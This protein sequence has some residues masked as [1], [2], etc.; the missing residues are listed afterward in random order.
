MT[1]WLASCVLFRHVRVQRTRNMIYL[2]FAH[3]TVYPLYQV[4]T[5]ARLSH[6]HTNATWQA[7]MHYLLPH[8]H[9]NCITRGV[10]QLLI[11]ENPDW[12][13]DRFPQIFRIRA[14][15]WSIDFPKYIV[16]VRAIDR[17]IDFP[18]YFVYV[19]AIDRLIDWFTRKVPLA[20]HDFAFHMAIFYLWNMSLINSLIIRYRQYNSTTRRSNKSREAVGKSP[21]KNTGK[22]LKRHQYNSHSIPTREWRKQHGKKHLKGLKC[23][24]HSIPTRGVTKKEINK[25]SERLMYAEW[26]MTTK[27]LTCGNKRACSMGVILQK[28]EIW[29]FHRIFEAFLWG[30]W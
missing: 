17:L 26:W 8:L 1:L 15:S 21:Q 3:F 19:R 11:V 30:N 5:P 13:V 28:E 6:N 18:K 4:R 10:M 29:K 27:V 16:Y 25:Q 7:C 23:N 12:R 14:S 24:S 22:N 20:H 9:T 2:K